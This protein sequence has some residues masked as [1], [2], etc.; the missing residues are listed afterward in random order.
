MNQKKARNSADIDGVNHWCGAGWVRGALKACGKGRKAA[1][2][3]LLLDLDTAI[4][5]EAY[6][7]EL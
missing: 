6:G 7:R 1:R 5:G 2:A 4:C 3:C